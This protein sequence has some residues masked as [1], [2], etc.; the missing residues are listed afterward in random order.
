M[1]MS[2]MGYTSNNFIH[3]SLKCVRFKFETGR[4]VKAKKQVHILN[5]LSGGSFEQIVERRMD[6]QGVTYLLQ[7]DQAFFGIHYLFQRDRAKADDRKGMAAV[8]ILIH[9]QHFLRIFFTM[10]LA[11]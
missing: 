2:L 10:Q 8:E 3:Y 7:L 5:G 9:C 4:F 6:H 1:V 11:A